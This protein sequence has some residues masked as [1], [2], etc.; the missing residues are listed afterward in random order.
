[1]KRTH[2]SNETNRTSALGLL[3]SRSEDDFYGSLQRAHNKTVQP[4]AEDLPEETMIYSFQPVEP[5]VNWWE[6]VR[7]VTN[8]F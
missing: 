6:S 1:M 8:F 3:L 7:L 2:A 4:S 5:S